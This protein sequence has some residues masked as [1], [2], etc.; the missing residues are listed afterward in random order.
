LRE[1]ARLVTD[2]KQIFLEQWHE[3]FSRRT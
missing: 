3:F 1:L 2:N